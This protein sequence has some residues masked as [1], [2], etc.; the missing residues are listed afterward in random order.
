MVTDHGRLAK[1]VAAEWPS[2]YV[3]VIKLFHILISSGYC[4]H[5]Q[6]VCLLC[7]LPPV[8]Q[9]S[10]SLLAIFR[11]ELGFLPPAPT[12]RNLKQISI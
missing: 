8:L 3:I 10:V 9:Q 6:A 4:R 2:W 5:M 1:F 7:F 12:A 11:L